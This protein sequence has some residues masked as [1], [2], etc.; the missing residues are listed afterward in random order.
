MCSF[1][2]LIYFIFR[3]IACFIFASCGLSSSTDIDCRFEVK[4]F[5]LYGDI[6]SCVV[7]NYPN[8]ATK[9][10]AQI[11]LVTGTHQRSKTN[12]DVIGFAAYS[13]TFRFFP[14]GLEKFFKNL[15]AIMLSG[16]P[17]KEIHQSSKF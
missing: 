3:F 5:Y 13:V 15:K 17:L 6:Y 9:E 16:C 4:N 11:S 10:S 2:Y 1:C 12:D 8:I 7:I 14:Q